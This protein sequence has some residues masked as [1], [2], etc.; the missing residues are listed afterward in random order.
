M[1]GLR[2]SLCTCKNTSS[3]LWGNKDHIF[4]WTSD[5]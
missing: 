3:R 4:K 2:N 1:R 5:H